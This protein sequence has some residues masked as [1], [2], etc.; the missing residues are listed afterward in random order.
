MLVNIHSLSR[1]HP[2]DPPTARQT[3]IL[4]RAAELVAES[5]LAN[6]TMKRVAERVGFTEP[7]IYRHFP[8]KQAL[9]RAMVERFGGRLLGT[10]AEIAAD[11]TLAPQERLL[12]MVRHHV[13]LLRVS[14]GLPL[15]LIAEGLASGD[16]GLIGQLGTVMRRY[17]GLLG[18][19]L[20][21]L[22]LDLG[23]A[24]ERQAT[25]FLGLPAAIGIQLRAFPDL[26][27]SDAETEI[28][29]RHYV[30][31][32]TTPAA[33]VAAGDRMPGTEAHP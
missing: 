10:I 5:G 15:L 11:R 26:A 25:L 17:A 9:V 32:L 23:V 13:S 22:D 28:L 14:R 12:A 3:E 21:E 6:L 7:A 1:I 18:G 24:P 20:A 2:S 16:N 8:G 4:D 27:L 33:P 30:R 31:S 29:V 19:V